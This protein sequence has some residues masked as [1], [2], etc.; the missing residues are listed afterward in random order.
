[1]VC[2]TVP[3]NAAFLVEEAAHRSAGIMLDRAHHLRCDAVGYQIA[4]AFPAKAVIADAAHHGDLAGAGEAPAAMA[5]FA[6]LPPK[7]RS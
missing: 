5:W 2:A 7:W 4:N 1:M 6:P 3:F